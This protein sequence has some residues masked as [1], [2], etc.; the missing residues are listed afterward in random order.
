MSEFELT[1]EDLEQ[2]EVL[3]KWRCGKCG[4]L[5]STWSFQRPDRC[6]NADCDSTVFQQIVHVNTVPATAGHEIEL[7]YDNLHTIDEANDRDFEITEQ[8]RDLEKLEKARR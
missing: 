5:Q 8:N 4:T 1:P 2:H 7:S 3:R 6:G